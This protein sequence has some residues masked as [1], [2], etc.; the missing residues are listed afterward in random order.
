MISRSNTK[1]IC[2]LFGLVFLAIYSFSFGQ[3][4]SVQS[5]LENDTIRIADQTFL[6]YTFLKNDSLWIHYPILG[7]TSLGNIEVLGKP[8]LDSSKSG[9][10]MWNMN[11]KLRV[12]AFDTGLFFI[13]PQSFIFRDSLNRDTAYSDT[14]FLKV[15]GV[16]LDT[17]IHDIKSPYTF[18][19]KSNTAEEESFWEKLKKLL[20]YVVPAL[21]VIVLLYFLYK[22]LR[23]KRPQQHL[24]QPKVEIEPPYIT[25][26][27]ELDRIKA[28]KLWQ[29]KQVKEYYT[30]ITHVIRWYIDKRFRI[31]ALE[32]TS[33]EILQQL[34]LNRLD[35]I[36]FSKLSDLLNL[37]DL[38]KFA[39][40]EPDAE[41]NLVH[42]ENAYEFIQKTRNDNPS[43]ENGS[44]DNK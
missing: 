44:E 10:G 14:V 2:L 32:L 15:V 8:S 26:F 36:N 6:T 22:Y 11:I 28:Q 23:N 5:K 3:S 12:T 4:I 16:K 13:P 7:D 19:K 35:D 40:G 25:A 33:D 24:F 17:A 31:N 39:K 20:V 18:R 27:R 38:V 34:K 21:L 43:E 42:L 1:A 41:E 29:Q 9:G 30:R 37:A